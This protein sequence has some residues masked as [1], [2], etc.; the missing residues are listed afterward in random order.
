L[1]SGPH[2]PHPP[3]LLLLVWFPRLALNWHPPVAVSQVAGMGHQTI[4]VLFTTI[5]PAPRTVPDTQKELEKHLSEWRC[6]TS[7][8]QTSVQLCCLLVGSKSGCLDVLVA[9]FISL[10][11][12]CRVSQWCAPYLHLSPL[13]YCLLRLSQP[14]LPL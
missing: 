7:S 4:F 2:E 1:N 14:V 10:F 6:P 11:P 12:L 3:V 9:L 13:L 5:F 8:T